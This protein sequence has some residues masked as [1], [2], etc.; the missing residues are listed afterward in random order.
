MRIAAGITA[1]FISG[2]FGLFG[3]GIFIDST[4][5]LMSG[6]FDAK[7]TDIWDNEDEFCPALL[8]VEYDGE[9]VGTYDCADADVK[10]GDTVSLYSDFAGMLGTT[11]DRVFLLVMG[12]LVSGGATII[13]G[14]VLFLLLAKPRRRPQ[15][16][17][18]PTPASWLPPPPT[19]A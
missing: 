3:L 4:V 8:R 18:D 2:V 12:L 14:A 10:V 6:P 9:R 16:Q 17:P 7:V 5:S 1:I 19:D 13:S 15:P 11:G